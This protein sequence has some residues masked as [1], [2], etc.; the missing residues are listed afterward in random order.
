MG[1]D[2]ASFTSG[3]CWAQGIHPPSREP[4]A[5]Q[6][7]SAQTS[8]SLPRISKVFCILPR[9]AKSS[10]LLS[11][12]WVLP[13]EPRNLI[14]HFLPQPRAAGGSA[15]ELSYPA[16]RQVSRIPQR[17]EAR[18]ST[19]PFLPAHRPRGWTQSLAALTE[20][21]PPAWRGWRRRR[22]NTRHEP[23]QKYLGPKAREM[24][25]WW[26]RPLAA[27]GRR[28]PRK[29]APRP[30]S[31]GLSHPS[32]TRAGGASEVGPTLGLEVGRLSTESQL[33]SDGGWI[34]GRPAKAT[35]VA[36]A[37]FP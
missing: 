36:N 6:A 2:L 37:R 32:R 20:S 5:F 9:V 15:C 28:D 12:V 23:P 24:G 25:H 26:P 19:S 22:G 16:T 17:Q 4:W 14:H 1:P 27:G 34:R 10:D 7:P 29:R 3:L 30:C 11:R 33:G 31:S 35:G 8:Q 18:R 13:R 21:W